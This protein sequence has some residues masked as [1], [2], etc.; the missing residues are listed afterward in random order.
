VLKV[1]SQDNNGDKYNH[2]YNYN[3]YG[4]SCKILQIGCSDVLFV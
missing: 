1:C 3:N 4:I 2:K